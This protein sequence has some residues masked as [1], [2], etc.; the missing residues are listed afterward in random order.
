MAALYTP[1]APIPVLELCRKKE[2]DP[3]FRVAEVGVGVSSS[4]EVV[5]VVIVV[6][7]AEDFSSISSSSEY[8]SW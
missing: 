7:A 5:V 3:G 6:A 4:G 2:E 1:S 8:L